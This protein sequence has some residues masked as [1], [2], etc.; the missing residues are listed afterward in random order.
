MKTLIF[1]ILVLFLLPSTLMAQKDIFFDMVTFEE[2]SQTADTIW[3]NEVSLLGS[4]EKAIQTYFSSEEYRKKPEFQNLRKNV[5]NFLNSAFIQIEQVAKQKKSTGIVLSPLLM[6]ALFEVSFKTYNDIKKIT[7]TTDKI[8]SFNMLI[9]YVIGVDRGTPPPWETM[10]EWQLGRTFVKSI[11]LYDYYLDQIKCNVLK[12][13]WQYI[14]YGYLMSHRLL[15]YSTNK[16]SG[17]KVSDLWIETILS[18][19]KKLTYCES[20]DVSNVEY[21]KGFPVSNKGI[22]EFIEKLY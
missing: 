20:S 15:Y 10:M 16:Y 4:E 8:H 14:A 17:E 2:L 1:K 21:L 13:V 9:Y 6:Q 5:L 18:S 12:S 7:T 22:K 3:Q 11:I 19:K